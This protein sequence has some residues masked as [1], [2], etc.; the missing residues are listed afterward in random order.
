MAMNTASERPAGWTTTGPKSVDGLGERLD[1]WA[2]LIE[3]A[4][5]KAD[6]VVKAFQER[7]SVRQMPEVAQESSG[8]TTGGL[9]GKQRP[10]QL[11]HTRTGATLTVYIGQFGRDLYVAWDLFVRPVWNQRVILG[12]LGAAAVLG[13]LGARDSLSGWIAATIG[14][15]IF[16]A[17]LVAGAGLMLK[18]NPLAFFWRE[19]TFFDADD[20]TAMTLA[21][22]KSLLQAIDAVGI[23]TQLLRVKEQFHGGRRDRLI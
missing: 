15:S 22:H 21:V 8:L 3:G 10:Y 23:D 7:I 5:D 18:R 6:E 14:L 17:V 11:V 20:I 19:L 9:T 12:I 16:F 4:R 13:L 1:G 2:E